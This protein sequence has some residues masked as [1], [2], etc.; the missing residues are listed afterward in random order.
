MA[1]GPKKRGEGKDCQIGRERRFNFVLVLSFSFPLL[2]KK[3]KK[4]GCVP[5]VH[6][7][8][9][10]LVVLRFEGCVPNSHFYVMYNILLFYFYSA[11][12]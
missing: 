7:D 8:E 3:K 4:F 9:L 2:N 6:N 1:T 5:I 11:S 10:L 12:C